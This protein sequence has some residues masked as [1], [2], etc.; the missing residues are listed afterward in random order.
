MYLFVIYSFVLQI[1]GIALD[2]KY[3]FPVAFYA[4]LAQARDFGGGGGGV[5]PERLGSGVW[6]A[7]L[8]TR[9]LPHLGPNSVIF[10]AQFM[11]W[12]KIWYSL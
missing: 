3:L 5:L 12:P 10:P 2:I 8:I 6:R 11:T 1:Y 9:P 4:F 7:S